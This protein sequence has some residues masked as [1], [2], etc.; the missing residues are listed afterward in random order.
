MG[1][2]DVARQLVK[3]VGSQRQLASILGMTEAHLSRVLNGKKAV[4]DY[5][6][7]ILELLEALPRKDWPDRWR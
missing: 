3:A 5:M 6:G 4:P 7:L 2:E 1:N